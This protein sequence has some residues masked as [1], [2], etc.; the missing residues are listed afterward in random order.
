MLVM[1]HCSSTGIPEVTCFWSNQ[2]VL[3]LGLVLSAQHPVLM[4]ISYRHMSLT[5]YITILA[6]VSH[7]VELTAPSSTFSLH[8][9]CITI[10]HKFLQI[11]L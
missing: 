3:D 5:I 8:T 11:E 7:D 4:A 1:S 2:R 9:Y 10:L 6:A